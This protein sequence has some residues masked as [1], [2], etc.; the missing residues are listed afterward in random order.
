MFALLGMQSAVTARGILS[1]HLSVTFQYCVQ[2][3][4]NM[5][6]RFLA[7]GRTILLVSGQ[8]K[9]IRIIAGDHPQWGH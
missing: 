7:S 2:T 6:V 3:N 4:E 5:I 1:V 8:E 9:F